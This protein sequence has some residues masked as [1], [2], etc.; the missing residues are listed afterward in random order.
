M[1]YQEQT[2]KWP[3][4]FGQGLMMSERL[5]RSALLQTKK[6][7]NDPDIPTANDDL[8]TKIIIIIDLLFPF[9]KF[10]DHLD[11]E[12][13]L[14]KICALENKLNLFDFFQFFGIYENIQNEHYSGKQ[15]K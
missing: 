8:P 4:T 3:Y 5:L 11:D 7:K 6:N 2:L 10:L 13:L 14:L 1:E 15:T 9:S 12:H